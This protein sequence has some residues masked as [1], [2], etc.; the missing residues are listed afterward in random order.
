MPQV[1][2]SKKYSKFIAPKNQ[3]SVNSEDILQKYGI[4]S[5]ILNVELA[6][7]A[8]PKFNFTI[9]DPQA[10]W[11]NTTLFEP[12]KTVEAKMGYGVTLETVM[13]GE[14]VAVKTIFSSAH[15]PEIEVSGEGKTAETAASSLIYSLVY[16]KTLLN[17]TATATSENPSAKAATISRTPAIKTQTGSLRCT[18]ECI[19]LPD[20]KPGAALA[21]S[22][23]GS[24][25]NMNYLVEKAVHSWDGNFGF[26]TRFEAKRLL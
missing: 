16:S 7:G 12:S 10:K 15:G 17:F 6:T 3:I 8:L 11:I 13:A 2:L 23:L 4:T 18:A 24:R 9:D 21:L 26:R 5:A 22:G 1:D 19:G 25:F 20:V 14:V